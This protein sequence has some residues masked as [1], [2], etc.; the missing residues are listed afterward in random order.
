MELNYRPF[1]DVE[2]CRIKWKRSFCSEKRQH[3]DV[4]KWPSI[5]VI[6]GLSNDCVSSS[7]GRTISVANWKG[8]G[9]GRGPVSGADPKY[10]RRDE[11]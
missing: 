8:C 7:D 1:F 11:M 4:T 9:S 3:G 2:T 10:A 6:C 5:A